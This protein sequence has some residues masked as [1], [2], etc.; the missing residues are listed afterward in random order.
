MATLHVVN[1]A[2]VVNPIKLGENGHVEYDWNAHL[3]EKIVQFYFQLVRTTDHS[4]LETKFDDILE[5]IFENDTC[6]EKRELVY[7]MIAQTRDIVGGKGEYKLAYMMLYNW[8]KKDFIGAVSLLRFFMMDTDILQKPYGSWKDAKYFAEYCHE[9]QESFSYKLYMEVIDL[10]NEQ[11]MYDNNVYETHGIHSRLSLC[12]KWI[13]RENKKYGWMYEQLA[14]DYY[15]KTTGIVPEE[16]SGINYAKMNY[17]KTLTK[18]NRQLDTVQIDMCAREW[19]N[20]NFYNI[21]SITLNKQQYALSYKYKNGIQ[22]T[23]SAGLEYS[24]DTTYNH[25]PEKCA[26][27]SNNKYE[28]DRL[29]CAERFSTWKNAD[30]TINGTHLSIY[31]FVKTAYQLNNHPVDDLITMLNKQWL[32][33]ASISEANVS[34]N[35]K[36]NASAS[37]KESTSLKASASTNYIIPMIDISHSMSA[38]NN[39]PLYTAIGLGIRLAENSKLGKRC[40]TFSE[41]PEWINLEHTNTFCECVK[42]LRRS[43]R[44]STANFNAAMEKIVEHVIATNMTS[45]EVSQLTVIVLSDMQFNNASDNPI[46]KSI[47]EKFAAAGIQICGKPYNPPRIVFWNLRKTGG[48]PTVSYRPGAAMVSGYNPRIIDS[49]IKANVSEIGAIEEYSPYNILK[50]IMNHPRYKFLSKQKQKND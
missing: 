38:E 8:A 37:P 28:R 4:D 29:M 6:L 5:N 35:T 12:A 24:H 15:Y 30:D 42:A 26:D 13:P 45:D 44:S 49:F 2:T 34:A 27:E 33:S 50:G 25:R 40:I 36:E 10:I 7:H 47:E 17:R 19:K 22:R 18:L 43:D 9:R 48:F 41:K 11:L 31:D 14:V 3:Q 20:L 23:A 32:A 16:E 21:S 1:P 46:D 39:I